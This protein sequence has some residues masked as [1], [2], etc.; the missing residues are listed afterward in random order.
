MVDD[1]FIERR[2]IKDASRIVG[3]DEKLSGR[4][5]N[6]VSVK[7]KIV[8]VNDAANPTSST[9]AGTGKIIMT[10]TAMSARAN[11]MVGLNIRAN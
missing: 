4:S 10:I 11:K 6:N 8:K 5:M 3:K 1:T 7:I 2:S 9:Q